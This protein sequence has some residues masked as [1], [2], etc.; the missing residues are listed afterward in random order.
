MKATPV[1]VSKVLVINDKDE[2][3]I[4]T[5]GEYKARPDK[6]FKPDLP[7][8][9]V[10]S[11]ETELFAVR[12]ELQEEAGIELDEAAFA[13]AYARTEYFVDS[14]ESVTKFLYLATVDSTPE[15]TL[16][17]EHASYEWV[18]LERLKT[19]RMLRPFYNEA[20]EYCF[21]KGLLRISLIK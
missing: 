21:N 7:G 6:S 3:L 8:G 13:L 12:R 19:A 2:A 14:N 10:D 17:W 20:V 4:L 9:L 15:V 16:S 5:V 11:G 1:S 18:P